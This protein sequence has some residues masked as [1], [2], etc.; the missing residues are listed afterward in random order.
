MHT[1]SYPRSLPLVLLRLVNGKAWHRG[2]KGGVVAAEEFEVPLALS[3]K[4]IHTHTCFKVLAVRQLPFQ[5]N[6][7]QHQAQRTEHAPA[8]SSQQGFGNEHRELTCLLPA[9]RWQDVGVLRD[10]SMHKVLR[11]I[12]VETPSCTVGPVSSKSNFCSMRSCS[13]MMSPS[14]AEESEANRPLYYPRAI[15]SLAWSR[16]S[17]ARGWNLLRPKLQQAHMIIR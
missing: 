14:P 15:S 12:H 9:H 8:G 4:Y 17:T 13:A 2:T 7:A 1:I 3:N 5:L 10:P 6:L 11:E 16:R